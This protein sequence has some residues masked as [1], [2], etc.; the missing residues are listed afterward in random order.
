MYV[1]IC[2]CVCMCICMHVC[3]Y[4]SVYA[5]MHMYVCIIYRGG[6][7][8]GGKCS[9]KNRRGNCPEVN[10]PGGNCL[11]LVSFTQNINQT[12]VTENTMYFCQSIKPRR[13]LSAERL[14][15]ASSPLNHMKLILP[16][17]VLD[18]QSGIY[19]ASNL[20]L[21]NTNN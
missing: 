19:L 18:T 6:I 15:M 10:C 8:R 12:P 21:T 4:M 20:N 16:P 11:T 5:Y 13:S 14:M 7:V 1:C 9:T 3:M 2:M 17:I